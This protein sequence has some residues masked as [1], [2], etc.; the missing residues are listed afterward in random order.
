MKVA[1]KRLA[2]KHDVVAV[3]IGDH[4]RVPNS[5]VGQSPLWDRERRGAIVD[6]GL[7][8]VQEVVR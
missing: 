3:S 8:R 5:E 2:R 1:L 4:P 7:L 6:T